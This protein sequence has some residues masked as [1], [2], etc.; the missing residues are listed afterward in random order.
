MMRTMTGLIVAALLVAASALGPVPPAGAQVPDPLVVAQGVDMQT[1]DPHRTTATH[2]VN[3]LANLYDTLVGRD[4]NLALRPA[5]AVSWRA[6]DATTWEFKLRPGVK[7][8]NGE[9]FNA[10]AVKFSFE[11][12]LDPKTKWPG[13][14]ALRPIKAV[15]VV[16]D[17]TVRFTTERPWPL[18]PRYLGYYGMIVPPG[19]LAQ[20]GDEGLIRQPVGTGAYRFV[21]WVKDDRVE[22]EA[23]ADYWGGKPRIGRVVFRA[24][25]SESSRLA[26]LLAGSI[27]LMNLVPPELFKPIQDSSRAKLVEGKSLSVYFVIANLVNIAKDRPMADP[28]VRQALNHAIDRQA[29]LSS[30]MHNVG[31]AVP[32]VCT[33]VMLGCDASVPPFAYDP[34]R[35]KALLREAGYPNGFD[36]S[37]STTSGAYPG[38]RDVSLAVADQLN[39]V[40]VRTK[41]NVTEYGVQLKTVQARQLTEDGWFTRFTDFFGLSTIIPFRAF[42]SPGEWSLWRPGHR[43]FDQLVESANAARDEAQMRDVSRRIQLLYKEEAPAISLFT[44]PNVYG[45]HP[46]LDWTP[47][48]DLLLTMFDA[49]WRKR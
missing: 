3:V 27:H 17:A 29:I 22:L 14:G 34:E 2:A 47:R 1:G 46:D 45:M 43:E 36:F 35:A 4:A 38:D 12:M 10:Q 37:M 48:P 42:Y 33:E 40:G 23:N 24:I 32:T 6:V 11:R 15:T 18:L 41:V 49:G 26:E 9:P 7:F 5:L 21:R 39:R 28:R 30:I 44:A 19:Y 8:H 31:R 16:D 20:N 25:P 13:A